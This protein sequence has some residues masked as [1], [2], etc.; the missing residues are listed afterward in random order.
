MGSYH[1]ESSRCNDE[2]L[3]IL[4]GN[5]LVYGFEKA[6]RLQGCRMEQ[7]QVGEGRCGH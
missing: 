1:G 4:E 6:F 3:E 5:G 7:G 2:S